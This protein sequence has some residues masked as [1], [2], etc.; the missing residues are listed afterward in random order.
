MILIL[1]ASPDEK[2]QSKKKGVIKMKKRKINIISFMNFILLIL[3]GITLLDS[4]YNLLIKP[5]FTNEMIGLTQ[6][7]SAITLLAFVTFV[8]E[9][10]Y[11]EE[12]LD[13]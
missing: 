13:K 5:F 9:F 10:Q 8:F 3:S 1:V 6:F 2:S 7:G 4:F 12:K 11:F